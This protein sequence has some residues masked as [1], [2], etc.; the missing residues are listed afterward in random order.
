MTCPSAAQPRLPVLRVLLPRAVRA[1]RAAQAVPAAQVVR[2]AQAVRAAQ[3]VWVAQAVPQ[4]A[5]PQSASSSLS[6]CT[7]LKW[8]KSASLTSN[9]VFFNMKVED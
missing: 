1:V 5:N 3:A 9:S 2:V 8:P 7:L 6:T 4:P